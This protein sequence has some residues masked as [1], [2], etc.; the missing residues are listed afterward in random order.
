MPQDVPP[1]IGEK[2]TQEEVNYTRSVD[3]RACAKCV[4]FLPMDKCQKV[5]GTVAAGGVCDEF[6][7]KDLSG[8]SGPS[9]EGLLFG[10]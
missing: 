10:G 6:Q 2:F 9:I 5:K 3:E 7:D 4:S 1:G 8:Q